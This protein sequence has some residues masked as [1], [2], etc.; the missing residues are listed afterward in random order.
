VA[1]SDDI[2]MDPLVQSL[3]VRMETV[4]RTSNWVQLWLGAWTNV[5]W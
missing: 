4:M 3:V 1:L 2:A 5:G